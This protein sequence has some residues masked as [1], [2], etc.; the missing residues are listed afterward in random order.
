M[1]SALKKLWC[2]HNLFWSE[3]HQAE[4]CRKCG[5]LVN[6]LASNRDVFLP[7][8]PE[9]A[10]PLEPVSSVAPQR[11]PEILDFSHV[12]NEGAAVVAAANKK[13]RQRTGGLP[14]GAAAR[15][16]ALASHFA[17]LANGDEL[18]KIEVLDLV[19]GLLEDAHVHDPLIFGPHAASHFADL[20]QASLDEWLCWPRAEARHK[21]SA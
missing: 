1:R 3:R 21:Q 15:R 7:R 19:M 12:R 10:A 2:T 4:R 20:H 18:G 17:R 9:G 14:V 6:Q 16:K 5:K 11:G 13:L 8:P